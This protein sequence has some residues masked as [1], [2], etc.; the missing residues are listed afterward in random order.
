MRLDQFNYSGMVLR[1]LR[2]GAGAEQLYWIGV[3]VLDEY[4]RST[5]QRICFN[6]MGTVGERE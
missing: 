1:F 3:E 6:D 5:R 2:D 4:C